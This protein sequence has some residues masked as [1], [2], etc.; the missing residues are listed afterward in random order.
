MKRSVHIGFVFGFAVAVALAVATAAQAAAVLR[1]SVT[2]DSDMVRLGDLFDDAGDKADVA[3]AAAP[4]FG[5]TAVYDAEWLFNVARANG[6][7]WRPASRL[8]R[9]TVRRAA[10]AMTAGE[11]EDTLRG[12]IGKEIAERGGSPK[13][14][15]AL[16]NRSL[17]LYADPQAKSGLEVRDIWLDRDGSRFTA[18]VAASNSPSA[19]TTKVSGRL[20]ELTSVPVLTRRL[21][22]KEVVG[23]GDVRFIDVRSDSLPSDAITDADALIGM[24]PRRYV[25]DGIPLRAGDFRE[26]IVVTKNSLV[27]MVVQTPY[28]LLTAQGRAVQDGA[29]GD[30][31][32]VMNTFSK[33][34][35]DAV[36]EGPSRVLVKTPAT[37]QTASSVSEQAA[38]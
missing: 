2:V 22:A 23:P 27:T 6:L 19:Q 37:A 20:Y 1:N 31:I 8:D 17:T 5:H 13:V 38:K 36:V 3:I 7:D 12:A 24:S 29:M 35:V 34:T 28:M 4:K 10:H 16:D 18:T 33:V 32:R 30:A 14:E 15:I 9:V 21:G 11:I 25:S 26:P